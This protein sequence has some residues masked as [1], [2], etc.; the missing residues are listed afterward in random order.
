MASP[1]L[2]TTKNQLFILR[3][4]QCSFRTSVL[5]IFFLVHS[6]LS[7][8]MVVVTRS[9]AQRRDIFFPFRRLP[10]E[11]RV[12]IWKEALPKR[13]ILQVKHISLQPGLFISSSML[14]L[15]SVCQE[16][17]NVT[18]NQLQLFQRSTLDKTKSLY[19]NPETDIL[20]IDDF[21]PADCIWCD[22]S[23]QWHQH[24]QL[25]YELPL[26][27]CIRHVAVWSLRLESHAFVHGLPA[28]EDIL[29]HNFCLS[30]PSPVRSLPASYADC[31]PKF[32]LLKDGRSLGYLPKRRNRGVAKGRLHGPIHQ[33]VVEVE[34][35]R[36]R[37]MRHGN[38][39]TI[40][41]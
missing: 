10:T 11:I 5:F 35:R 40:V 39:Y 22:R 34:M 14:P 26:T 36:V 18:R 15:P 24:L 38:G 32:V 9:Q 28:L 3:C 7:F 16:S 30:H 4:S 25:L 1:C 41:G 13:Q 20:W 12:M 23:R 29:L 6:Q 17:R 21:A 19:C 27:S 33:Q 8:T 37:L 31:P 2:S